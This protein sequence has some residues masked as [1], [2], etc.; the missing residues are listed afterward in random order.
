MG[1][2]V[3]AGALCSTQQWQ[4]LGQPWREEP[5]SFGLC[6]A[7]RSTTVRFGSCTQIQALGV[8]RAHWASI[9]SSWLCWHQRPPEATACRRG[10]FTQW[11][12]TFAQSL[13][14]AN[15]PVLP[16]LS[17]LLLPWSHCIP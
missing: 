3:L 12:P 8:N 14:V 4:K 5:R 6:G 15:L 10:E 11:E 2:D 17:H 16:C 9:L 1:P 7:S 13:L